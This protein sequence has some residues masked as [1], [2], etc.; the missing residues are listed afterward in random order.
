MCLRFAG[1]QTLII[2]SV[3]PVKMSVTQQ[4]AQQKQQQQQQQTPLS[5]PANIP[6]FYSVPS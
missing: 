3:R 2:E 5:L 6:N 1:Q 4:E